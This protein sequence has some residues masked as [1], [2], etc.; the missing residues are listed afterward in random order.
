MAI[1]RIEWFLS[2][3][4]NTPTDQVEKICANELDYLRVNYEPSSMRRALTNYRNGVKNHIGDDQLKTITLK[5]LVLNESESIALAAAKE[6]QLSNDLLN[7]RPLYEIDQY[8]QTA[9]DLLTATSYQ[10]R[11]LALCALTGRRAAEIGC[12]AKFEPI[13]GDPLNVMFTG[14]LKTK[15]RGNLEAYKIPVFTDSV[16]IIESLETIRVDKPQFINEPEKFHNTASKEL[17]KHCKKHFS[18][19]TDSELKVKDQRSIYGELAFMFLDDPT[20]AK[21]KYMSLIL[22]H[23]ADD[24]ATGTSYIDFYIADDNYI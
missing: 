5:F 23:G 21:Q 4:K 9:S 13:K 2:T 18:F 10:L 22:G 12:T 16:K 3:I 17:N 14:Q 20:I 19:V 11:T 1:S 24:N 8:I 7:L 6:K 15:G